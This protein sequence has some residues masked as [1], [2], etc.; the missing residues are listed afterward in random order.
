M[1]LCVL[2]PEKVLHPCNLKEII[3]PYLIP[4]IILLGLAVC[5]AKLVSV[6]RDGSTFYV[7]NSLKKK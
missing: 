7:C 2:Y 1:C 5:L 6:I 4:G 3:C